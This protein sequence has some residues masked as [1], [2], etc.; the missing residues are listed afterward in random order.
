MLFSSYGIPIP[1]SQAILAVP[2]FED[3]EEDEEEE[4]QDENNLD[5]NGNATS[6]HQGISSTALQI[7]NTHVDETNEQDVSMD[8]EPTT[9]VLA[10]DASTHLGQTDTTQ[11]SAATTDLDV[12][13]TLQKMH[14]SPGK[15]VEKTVTFDKSINGDDQSAADLSIQ[16]K[17][18]EP[19]Y[20]D[21]R[22][23]VKVLFISRLINP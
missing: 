4:D 19:S 10:M 6:D 20:G 11:I 9:S 21:V 22:I 13:S 7:T 15:A 2:P 17:S 5:S 12:A 23:V 8:L 1:R 14:D 3:D 18:E 16:V